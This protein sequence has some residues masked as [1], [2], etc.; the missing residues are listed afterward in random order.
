[1]IKEV[2]PIEAPGIAEG[3]F[4]EKILQRIDSM[5]KKIIEYLL[6]DNPNLDRESL[7]RYLSQPPEGISDEELAMWF[8]SDLLRDITNGED[9]SAF[10][11]LTLF[12][13][14]GNEKFP[15]VKLLEEIEKEEAE[16]VHDFEDR[17][18]LSFGPNDDIMLK[19]RLFEIRA[20]FI[21][22]MKDVD[23]IVSKGR[24]SV[25]EG[26]AKEFA[27]HREEIP[28]KLKLLLPKKTFDLIVS[29]MEKDMEDASVEMPAFIE[30]LSDV[31]N[32]RKKIREMENKNLH[33][34]IAERRA[35]VEDEYRKKF[36]N[37]VMG[38]LGTSVIEG[39][40]SARQIVANYDDPRLV[41][42]KLIGLKSG[43]LPDG[44]LR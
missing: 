10:I 32:D 13:E 17:Y 40:S 9:F 4:R 42:D 16:L 2:N 6:L 20:E 19:K 8:R 37:N 39:L 30:K 27:F 14:P 25:A 44:L 3:A 36:F 1:M 31:E 26:L 18:G 7:S 43:Q 33:P 11:V 12:I 22:K 5:Q 15:S 34:S 29:Q 23:A 38:G 41:F 35:S 24:Q 21:R 28:P